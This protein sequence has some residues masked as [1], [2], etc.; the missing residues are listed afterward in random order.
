MLNSRQ[1]PASEAIIS[2]LLATEDREKIIYRMAGDKCILVEVGDE[3]IDFRQRIYIY[4]LKHMIFK[5]QISGVQEITPGVRS[6]LITYDNLIV[7]AVDLVEILKVLD[8][9]INNKE[10]VKIPS[11]LF[12]LPIVFNDRWTKEAIERYRNT[13]RAEAPYL[14]DNTAFI[15]R[16]NGLSGSDEV[17]EKVLSTEYIVLA[18]GDGYLG[19]PLSVALDPR[20]RLI[21]PKYNP[22]RTYTKEGTI[23][24]GGSFLGYYAADVPGGYQLIGRSIPSFDKTQVNDA[25]KEYPWLFRSFDRFKFTSVTEEEFIEIRENLSDYTIKITDGVFAIEEYEQF[26]ASIKAETEAFNRQQQEAL[27]T[28]TVGL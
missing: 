11:R 23:A 3:K 14:P 20:C 25:Y 6:L 21:C 28:A 17:I 26:E 13:I 27:I 7:S 16:C 4:L 19:T 1:G 12:E 9:T 2:R 5:M 18:Q 15:A 8:Q 22:A 10:N 24:I